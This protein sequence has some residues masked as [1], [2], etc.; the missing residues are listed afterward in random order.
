[1]MDGD[2]YITTSSSLTTTL[3]KCTS[4]GNRSRPGMQHMFPLALSLPTTQENIRAAWSRLGKKR[5]VE[6]ALKHTW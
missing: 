4:K 3:P 2:A 6:H 5:W 1:M